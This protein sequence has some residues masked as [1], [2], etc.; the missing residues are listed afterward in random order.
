MA[1]APALVWI[2]AGYS[3][4]LAIG[5]AYI[6]W[7]W[8]VQKIGN[9]RTAAYSNLTPVVALGVAWA[10]LGETP[11]PLQIGGAA[12]VLLGLSLAR[13]GGERGG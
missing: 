2:G 7:L 5:L 8:G 4:I 12:V 3:G 1:E 11:G 10:W 13:L 6:L 9:S